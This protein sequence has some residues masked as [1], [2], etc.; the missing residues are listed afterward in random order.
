MQPWTISSDDEDY[1]DWIAYSTN[2]F[3]VYDQ[4]D[5]PYDFGKPREAPGL[6]R[7][8]EGDGLCN[9]DVGR[10]LGHVDRISFGSPRWSVG[11]GMLSTQLAVTSCGGTWLE[12]SPHQ[13][14]ARL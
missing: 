9:Y 13:F 10:N 6:T 5:M 14:V 11:G 2:D 4:K 1:N 3:L 7:R 8:Q 12:A